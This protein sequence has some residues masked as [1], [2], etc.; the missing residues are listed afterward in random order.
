M[1]GTALLDSRASQNCF[2]T[3]TITKNRRRYL[4]TDGVSNGADGRG[5]WNRSRFHTQRIIF[6]PQWAKNFLTVVALGQESTWIK[7]F[8]LKSS[9]RE[10]CPNS[11]SDTTTSRN[12]TKY[13]G[14]QMAALLSSSREEVFGCKKGFYVSLVERSST[15]I[16][17]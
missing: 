17:D 2:T 12:S 3:L 14:E 8:L 16:R 13:G 1:F 15:T 9:L 4:D 7:V 10:E 11:I 5:K 6:I